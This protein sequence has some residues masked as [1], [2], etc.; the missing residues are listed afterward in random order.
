MANHDVQRDPTEDPGK[1]P[2]LAPFDNMRPFNR[3]MLGIA[4]TAA[5]GFLILVAGA[6]LKSH[7]ITTLM[8]FGAT[9]TILAAAAWLA[10]TLLAIGL[11]FVNWLTSP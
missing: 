6:Y 9:I 7:T 8:A 4:I 11:S 1:R 5:I 2:T 10:A 3:V